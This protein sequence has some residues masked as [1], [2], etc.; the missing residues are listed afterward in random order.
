MIDL[1]V[2]PP[3][4]STE[5]RR[6]QFFGQIFDGLAAGADEVVVV[7]RVARDVR[8]DVTFALEPARHAILDLSLEGAVDGGT[9]DR[10]M[11]P[12]DA[13]SELLRAQR[14]PRGRQR[15]GD[16][17]ALLGQPS[18]AR[19]Q[20]LGNRLGRDPGS[21]LPSQLVDNQSHLA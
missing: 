1:K 4:D 13:V 14:A 2:V 19:G 9:S 7:L 17:D 11:A 8:P 10:R 5:H 6:D 15:F 16:D 3:P 21:I 18:S 20:A 12:L